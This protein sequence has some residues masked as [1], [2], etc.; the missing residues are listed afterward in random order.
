MRER[1]DGIREKLQDFWLAYSIYI[2]LPVSVTAFA[3]ALYF[4][5]HDV[6]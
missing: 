4:M 1:I 5:L 6:M 3:I 2:M